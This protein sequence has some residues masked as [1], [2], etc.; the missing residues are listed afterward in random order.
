MYQ[1]ASIV[2]YRVDQVGTQLQIDIPGVNLQNEIETKNMKKCGIWLDDGRHISA[3]QRKK[4]YATIKDISTYTGYLPE[5]Q[6]EWLKYLYV[7]RTGGNYIS[8]S[9][10]SM[11]EAREFINVILDYALEEGIQ[12]LDFGINRTDDINHYL[13]Y[14]IK[15]KVCCICGKHHADLHHVDAVGIGR[16]RKKIDDSKH[17]KMA[18]CREHHTEYH[19]IGSEKF[20]LKYKVY[21]IVYKED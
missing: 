12:L 5:I 13:Y 8:L 6:K 4:I 19:K 14:C 17:R 3:E 11:T 15:Q 18:L 20:T 9:D 1:L 7:E 21:G 2:A 10:C 16:D